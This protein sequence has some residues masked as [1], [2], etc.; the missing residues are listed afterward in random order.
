[1]FGKTGGM[2]MPEDAVKIIIKDPARVAKFRRH[3]MVYRMDAWVKSKDVAAKEDFPRLGSHR[4]RLP[5]VCR[6]S[7]S[8]N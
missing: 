7:K 5:S 2:V 3:G 1:M 4:Q 8:R 6:A